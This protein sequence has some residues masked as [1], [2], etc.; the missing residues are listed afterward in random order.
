MPYSH[1]LQLLQGVNSSG[2]AVKGNPFLLDGSGTKITTNSV[3][4]DTIKRD[5]VTTTSEYA[6][7]MKV[8]ADFN[9]AGWG[10]YVQFNFA[11]ERD[12]RFGSN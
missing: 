6:Y 8:S 2:Y 5:V 4:S 10:A 7:N 3:A 1:G 9:F 11:M 12:I